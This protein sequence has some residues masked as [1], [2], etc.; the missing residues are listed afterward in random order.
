LTAILHATLYAALVVSGWFA[1]VAAVGVLIHGRAWV[2]TRAR[3]PLGRATSRYR[4]T[5]APRRGGATW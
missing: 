1:L 4:R 3:E 5:G 2:W